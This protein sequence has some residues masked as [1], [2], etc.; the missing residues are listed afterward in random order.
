MPY[1]V[2]GDKNNLPFFGLKWDKTPM[3]YK[4]VVANAAYLALD[5]RCQKAVLIRD[6]V[7]IATNFID[8]LKEYNEARIKFMK[9]MKELC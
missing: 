1:T 3:N 5:N 6:G 4:E 8:T 2:V 7:V 9:G